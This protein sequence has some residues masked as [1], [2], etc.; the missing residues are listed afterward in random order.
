MEKID[1]NKRTE[2]PEVLIHWRDAVAAGFITEQSAAV[3]SFFDYHVTYYELSII[4]AMEA[5]TEA[6]SLRKQLSRLKKIMR[7]SGKAL[8]RNA[9]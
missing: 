5:K 3:S 7:R 6:A 9:R 1:A 8:S 2:N 4:E